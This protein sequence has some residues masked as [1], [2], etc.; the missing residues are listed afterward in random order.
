MEE[1]QVYLELN[2]SRQQDFLYPLIFRESIYALAHDH[3]LNKSMI[4][5]ENE[6]IENPVMSLPLSKVSIFLLQYLV[7]TISY[8]VSFENPTDH[9]RT[10]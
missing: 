2:R 7:L 5:L 8:Y 1:F 9:L 6:R 4:L 3:G 10:Q